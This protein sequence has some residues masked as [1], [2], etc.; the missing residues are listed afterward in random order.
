MNESRVAAPLHWPPTRLKARGEMPTQKTTGVIT[1]SSVCIWVEHAR[2]QAPEEES[3][4]TGRW[5]EQAQDAASP[6]TQTL[7]LASRPAVVPSATRTQTPRELHATA[8][9]T[10]GARNHHPVGRRGAS[11]VR[12]G[13]SLWLKL[14]KAK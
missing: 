8:P 4:T 12:A 9:C 14:S 11:C 10:A 6:L 5:V 13:D 3:G 7:A 1:S 2:R